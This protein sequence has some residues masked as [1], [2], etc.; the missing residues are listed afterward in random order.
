MSA[1]SSPP[2]SDGVGR[3]GPASAP[4]SDLPA[5]GADRFTL[6]DLARFDGS[7]PALPILIGYRGHV[8]DVSGKFMWMNGR[9]FWLRAGRDLTDRLDEAPHGEE[10]LEAAP[11]VGILVE[12]PEPTREQL[13]PASPGDATVRTGEDVMPPLIGTRTEQNLR[14]A[15]ADEAQA[16]Q[17]HLYLA[18]R[19][20]AAGDHPIVAALRTEAHREMLRAFCP[21]ERL[22]EAGGLDAVVRAASDGAGAGYPGMA[23]TAREEGFD[24]I[25]EMF[26]SL[27]RSA[28]VRAEG[29]RRML[30]AVDRHKPG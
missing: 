5:T 6:A 26:E 21:L 19:M 23:R 4:A 15:F 24:E 12:E 2:G 25:A 29:L 27:A 16:S 9:H 3:G 14:L 18:H 13:G 17:Y 10:M 20:Q 22:D 11:R 30:D 1:S 8:H 28:R 7:D